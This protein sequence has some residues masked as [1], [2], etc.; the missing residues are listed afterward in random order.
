MKTESPD[1][2][3]L[4]ETK[5]EPSSVADIEGYHK[6]FSIG[7]KAGYSGTGIFSKEKPIS[8]TYGI[9]VE[10]HDDEGRVITAEYDNFYVVT[11]YVPNSGRGLVRLEYRM[12][13]DKDL[14]NYLKKLDEKKPFIWCGDLNVAHKE[15]DLKN[16]KTNVCIIS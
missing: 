4:Q 2:I 6:Y 11:S 9:G 1:I 16:P 5:I 10:E 13:W 3:C 8:V 12:K 14:F 15:L 7:S